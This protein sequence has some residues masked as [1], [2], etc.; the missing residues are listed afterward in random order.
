[1]IRPVRLMSDTFSTFHPLIN[2]IF[3]ICAIVFGMVFF[4]PAYLAASLLC[5]AAYLITLR[6]GRALRLL[7]GLIP[8]FLI[9]TALNPLFNTLG[10]TVLFTCFGRPYTREALFYGAAVAAMFCGMLVWFA[11]Y[12]DTMTSDK[13]LY[14]FG[15][16]APSVSL[17][18]TMVLRF[19]PNYRR[20]AAQ[21]EGARR[22]IGKG[23]VGG[24]RVAVENGAA[25]LSALTGWALEGGV[26]T[27]DSMRSRGFGTGSRTAYST[28]R[29]ARR[30]GVLVA[31]L[32]ALAA[33]VVIC[34]V[35]GGTRA[36]Y[37][38][39][40]F[41]ADLRQP[42]CGTGVA[43]YTCFLLLPTLINIVEDIK[44]H[45]LRSGI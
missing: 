32:L 43:A 12:H 23:A 21:I 39:V 27:A 10:E 29:F 33:V 25:T 16:L 41:A 17:I 28:Y 3:Y 35:R 4:H 1:M 31:V 22:C 37:T 38:P 15:R 45:I 7:A 36:A 5:A 44:W 30:D 13:F 40:F 34:A 2:F 24:K 6:R 19:I 8:V 42:W 9:L 20:K 18:L 11:A 26:I 14:L